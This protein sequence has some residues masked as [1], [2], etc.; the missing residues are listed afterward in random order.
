MNE[1]LGNPISGTRVT[2]KAVC[3]GVAATAATT[4]IV[5]PAGTGAKLEYT[6][7]GK[8][9]TMAAATFATP[10]TDIITGKAFVPLLANEGC[11]FLLAMD[12]GATTMRAAQGTIVPLNAGVWTGGGARSEFPALPD[13][14]APFAYIVAKQATTGTTWTFGTG[15]WNQAGLTCAVVD[16]LAVPS[17]PQVD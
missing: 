6:I 9:Y 13:T 15:N 1:N 3:T 11:V 14:L 5:T 16:I 12:S 8:A 10:T 4:V 17:R 7:K 2:N